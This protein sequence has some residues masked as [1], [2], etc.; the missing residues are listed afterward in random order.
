MDRMSK[1]CNKGWKGV[2]RPRRELQHIR[3]V[4]VSWSSGRRPGI[5]RRCSL[6]VE[7]TEGKY[8]A[9]DKNRSYPVDRI[10][11]Y[12]TSGYQVPQSRLTDRRTPAEIPMHPR[13]RLRPR[14]KY[15]EGTSGYAQSAVERRTGAVLKMM[16]SVYKVARHLGVWYEPRKSRPRAT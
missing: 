10:A 11:C 6:I 5:R 14:A 9:A 16:S 15:V 7:L 1:G 2:A 8:E 12:E 3:R 13:L 4:Q